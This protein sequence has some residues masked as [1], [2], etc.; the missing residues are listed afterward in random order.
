MSDSARGHCKTRGCVRHSRVSVPVQCHILLRCARGLN[1]DQVSLS[2]DGRADREDGE[3]GTRGP[4]G[5]IQLFEPGVCNGMAR[6]GGDKPIGKPSRSVGVDWDCGCVLEA[7]RWVWR[8]GT[9]AVAKATHGGSCPTKTQGIPSS[10]T[11]EGSRAD[12]EIDRG[13]VGSQW[14]ARF[15]QARCSC[16]AGD[17]CAVNDGW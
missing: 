6:L 14:R 17:G 5:G 10:S 8:S 9:S 13:A 4:L 2:E 16:R 1:R 12:K 7:R 3:R 15:A 11:E